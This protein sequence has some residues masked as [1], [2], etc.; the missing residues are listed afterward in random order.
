M[1]FYEFNVYKVTMGQLSDVISSQTHMNLIQYVVNR[2]DE[3]YS[4]FKQS[5]V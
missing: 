4:V 3:P 5:G 2:E 1:Y